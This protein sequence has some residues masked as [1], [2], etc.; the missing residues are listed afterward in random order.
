M[1]CSGIPWVGLD[2]RY[3]SS[4]ALRLG[5]PNRHQLRGDQRLDICDRRAVA[6]ASQPVR[7]RGTVA[8]AKQQ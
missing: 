2:L 6:V 8:E 5:R 7:Q 1:A 3:G 4:S